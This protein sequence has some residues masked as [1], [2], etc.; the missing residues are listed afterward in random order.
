M[1]QS[2]FFPVKKLLTVLLASA[3]SGVIGP[4]LIDANAH[5]VA[6]TLT[7][8]GLPD[9]ADLI[10]RSSPA[11]VNIRTTAKMH[12]AGSEALSEQEFLRRYFG[13][14]PDQSGPSAP[15]GKPSPQ[16]PAAEKMQ[17]GVGSGFI[18]TNDGYVMTN[19]HVVDGADEVFVKLSD[20]REFKA[21]VIGKDGRTDIALLKIDGSKLPTATIGAS[22]RTRVGEWVIAIGSPF[23]L[24][25]T[26]T[27]GIISAKARETGDFLPLIQTDVAINPGN[28]GGPLINMHGEVVGINS[29]IYSRSGGYMGISF[30]V[31]IDDAMQVANQLKATGH[32]TRGR[33]GVYLGDVSKE[34]AAA[35]GLPKAQGSLIGRIEKNGPA[36][37]AGLE[38]GDIILQF[39]GT[40]VLKSS[41]LRRLAAA[42]QPGTQVKLSIWRKGKRQ[43]MRLT[44]AELE[45][46]GVKTG[47]ADEPKKSVYGIVT[48]DLSDSLKKETGIASGVVIKEIDG[49][50][51]RAGLLAGDIILRLDNEDIKDGKHFSG[52]LAL[53][54]VEKPV[55]LLVRRGDM[56]QFIALRAAE[57]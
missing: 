6:A 4:A 13:A 52:L 5:A 56:S 3:F 10:D 2:D 37:L 24:D 20:G 57:K 39:D 8:A 30:A 22:A 16:P 9:F 49:V 31:A 11:V 17:R 27:A 18:L 54:D 23:D 40:A 48:D 25:N 19:A 38:G 41:D 34:I 14:P 46:D 45:R 33:L 15:K 42:T 12:Q 43:E 21:K 28:S 55:V 50:A 35:L 44:I 1:K 36:D 26:V 53:A 29:Q 7:P 51:A 47:Q 32:V